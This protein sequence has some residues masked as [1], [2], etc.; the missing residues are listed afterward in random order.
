MKRVHVRLL[1]VLLVLLVVGCDQWTKQLVRRNVT[2]PRS[3]FGGTLT[4]MRAENRGA[5]LSFGS[6]LPDSLRELILI[7][8]VGLFVAAV[9]AMAWR[10][11]GEIGRA[12]PTALIAAGGTGNLIDRVARGGAVTDFMLLRAGML[13]TGIFNVADLA[14]T[15]GIAALVLL[16][17]VRRKSHDTR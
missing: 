17:L 4:I 13:H 6:E 12:I 8:G 3:M 1:L 9:F 5:F 14:I 16:P 11:T 2:T 10:S 7:A 15:G